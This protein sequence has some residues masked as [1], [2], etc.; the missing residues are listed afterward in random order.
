[1]T[2]PTARSLLCP[3]SVLGGADGTYAQACPP[4]RRMTR[5]VSQVVDRVRKKAEHYGRD[6]AAPGSPKARA[7]HGD[8]DAPCKASLTRHS[9]APLLLVD[10][11]YHRV[12]AAATWPH[13]GSTMMRRHGLSSS[14]KL[15]SQMGTLAYRRM[16]HLLDRQ[17]QVQHVFPGVLAFAGGGSSD[18]LLIRSVPAARLLSPRMNTNQHA[19]SWCWPPVSLLATRMCLAIWVMLTA[20]WPSTDGQNLD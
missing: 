1:M 12:V 19:C 15:R 6:A 13:A 18:W 4:T 17:A 10:V 2:C 14:D 11:M 5:V 7:D 20:E 16:E 9:A 3:A 8:A